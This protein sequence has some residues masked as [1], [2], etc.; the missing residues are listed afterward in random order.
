MH[1]G[2][3]HR[4]P[5]RPSPPAGSSS[6]CTTRITE[7]RIRMP[8]SAST[9]R[10]ATKPKGVPAR[11]HRRHHADQPE[12]GDRHDQEQ[13]R[14]ALQLDHQDR[15]HDEQHQRDHRGDRSLGL[16]ALL[17]GAADRHPIAGRE[18]SDELL[19]LGFELLD[20]RRRLGRVDD[21]AA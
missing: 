5:W 2:L 11:Q 21:A 6:I 4:V 8:T 16:G 13:P 18:R 12:R 9:P 15:R 17:D 1:G 3:D 10:M 20:Q 7:L 14:E 19:H